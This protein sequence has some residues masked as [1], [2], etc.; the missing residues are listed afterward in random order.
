LAPTTG[1]PWSSWSRGTSRSKLGVFQEA[2]ASGLELPKIV[3]APER[4]QACLDAAR[5][6]AQVVAQVEAITKL[7]ETERSRLA[8]QYLGR[9]IVLVTEAR[10]GSPKRSEEIKQDPHLKALESRPEFRTVVDAQESA[11]R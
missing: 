8:R 3:S 5:I 2:A 9:T 6:L 10:D 11:Q 1:L 7:P 4:S